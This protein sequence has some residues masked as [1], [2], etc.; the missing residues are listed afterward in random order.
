VEGFP[1]RTAPAFAK[2]AKGWATLPNKEAK[3]L[4]LEMGIHKMAR[5]SEIHG[6]TITLIA[7][8]K[9]VEPRTL[10]KVARF[11]RITATSC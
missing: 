9:R 5:L 10:A 11:Q 3:R 1:D 4:I 6:D 2:S 8:G 7:N